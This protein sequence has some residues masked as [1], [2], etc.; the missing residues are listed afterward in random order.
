MTRDEA[1]KAYEETFGGFPYFL[2]MG[3]SDDEVVYRVRRALVR[4]KEIEPDETDGDY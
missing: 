1:I 3:A 2:L 4:N